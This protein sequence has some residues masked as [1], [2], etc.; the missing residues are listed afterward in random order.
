LFHGFWLALPSSL[1]VLERVLVAVFHFSTLLLP[2]ND[3]IA[4]VPASVDDGSNV[5]RGEVMEV[6]AS[7]LVGLDGSVSTLGVLRID[8]PAAFPFDLIFIFHLHIDVHIV[9]EWIKEVVIVV[10][11]LDPL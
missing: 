6:M 1:R 5:T 10:I 2:D 7:L 8:E 9:I 11:Q 3:D 4:G